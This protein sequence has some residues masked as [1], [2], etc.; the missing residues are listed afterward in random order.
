MG[1]VTS[2]TIPPLSQFF[3]YESIKRRCWARDFVPSPRRKKEFRSGRHS[4][5]WG[6]TMLNVVPPVHDWLK[7][8]L[9]PLVADGCPEFLL[10]RGSSLPLIPNF[11]NPNRNAGRKVGRHAEI[12]PVDISIALQPTTEAIVKDESAG[13]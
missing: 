12:I 1:P 13:L 3:P 8:V 2:V 9:E 5:G 7:L 11:R 10:K 6:Q 4:A